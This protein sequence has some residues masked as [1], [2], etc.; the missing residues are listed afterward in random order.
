[1][2]GMALSQS[3]APVG[4]TTA[5]SIGRDLSLSGPGSRRQIG[6]HSAQKAERLAKRY[7]RKFGAAGRDAA[8]TLLGSAAGSRMGDPAIATQVG[9]AAQNRVRS[10][11][12]EE[13]DLR[14]REQEQER[15]RRENM[16]N[17]NFDPFAS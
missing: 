3:N 17:P 9:Q 10:E 13:F 8:S 6:N 1:M 11:Q 7:I 16:L 12:D 4:T 5:T 15:R 14:R 2:G